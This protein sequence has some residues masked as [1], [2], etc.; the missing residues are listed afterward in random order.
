MSRTLRVLALTPYPIEG[1]SSRYRVYQFVPGLSQEGIFLE[2]RPFMDSATYRKRMQSKRKLGPA[3]LWGLAGGMV[4]RLASL[5]VINRYDAV[6]V[7]RQMAPVLHGPIN[8]LLRWAKVP[9]VYDFDDAVFTS[10][11]IMDILRHSRVVFAGNEYLAEYARR[12]GHARVL[13]V[14]TVVDTEQFVPLCWKEN[15]VPVVGWIG[16]EGSFRHYLKPPL[17]HLVAMVHSHGAVFR[18]IGPPTIRAEVEAEGAEFVPWALQT[19]VAELGRL[20]IGVMPL[21]MDNYVLGKCAFKLVQYGAMGLP[22]VGSP[23]GANVEVIR[24]GETGFLADTLE[25]WEQALGQLLTDPGLRRQMGERARRHVVERFSLA[26]Q[27][28]EV[29][30]ALRAVA[31]R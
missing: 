21:V 2:I 13:V 17:S 23:I 12:H 29:C 22:S 30:D 16:T 24:H 26:T 14:P 1:P 3:I 19:E 4:Q 31:G 27:I 11:T 18:V 8:K 15:P 7:H 6:L 20:D 9:V 5:L 10:H 28:S 25:A